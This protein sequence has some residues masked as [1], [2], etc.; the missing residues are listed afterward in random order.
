MDKPNDTLSYIFHRRGPFYFLNAYR[1]ISILSTWK[2]HKCVCY[3][4]DLLDANYKG[5]I[6]EILFLRR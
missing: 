2:Q 6:Q 5:G 1:N 3:K 4:F